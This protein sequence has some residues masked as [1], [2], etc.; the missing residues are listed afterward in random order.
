MRPGF[1]SQ[2]P[3]LEQLRARAR[4]RI[5]GFAF[6]YLE[7]GCNENVNLR[8]NMSDIQDVQ[9]RPQYLQEFEGSDASTEIFGQKYDAPF[10]ITALGLQGL[11]WP[12]SPEILA[13]AAAKGNVPF[14]LSTVSTS[15]IERIAEI[16]EGKAW[17]QLYYPADSKVR[18]DIIRRLKECG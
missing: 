17:Y 16:T 18:D 7:G 11:I 8:R 9:L 12:N 10:G 2:Y 1:I 4:K 14:M 15:S 5:P 13:R 3:D 6:D